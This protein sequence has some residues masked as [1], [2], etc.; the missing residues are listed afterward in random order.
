MA[1]SPNEKK[2]IRFRCP[3][4]TRSLKVDASLAG[5]KVLCPVCY[6]ELIVPAQSQPD[7]RQAAPGMLYGVDSTPRDNRQLRE[8]FAYASVHCPVCYADVAV[9]KSQI[10]TTIECPDCGTKLPVTQQAFD[11]GKARQ[12]QLRRHQSPIDPHRGESASR[13]GDIYGV[14]SGETPSGDNRRGGEDLIPVYCTLC[15]TLMYARPNQIGAELTCPDCETKVV[16]KPPAKLPPDTKFPRS[17]GGEV[18]GLSANPQGYSLPPKGETAPPSDLVPVRCPLCETLLYAKKSQIGKKMRCP[19]C[20]TDI[21]ICDLTVDQKLAAQRIEPT[22]TGGYNLGPAPAGLHENLGPPGSV[23]PPI[24]HAPASS[25]PNPSYVPR[26]SAHP[27]SAKRKEDADFRRWAHEQSTE[28]PAEKKKKRK[29]AKKQGTEEYNGW[30]PKLDDRGNVILTFPPPP[31]WPMAPSLFAPL[32]DKE[33]WF[34]WFGPIFLVIASWLLLQNLRSTIG[35]HGLGAI[36]PVLFIPCLLE[37][38]GFFAALIFSLRGA[39]INMISVFNAL[40]NGQK[41]VREW[42]NREL[43]DGFIVLLRLMVVELFVV[44]PTALCARFGIP[45]VILGAIAYASQILFFPVA[46]L[47]TL[48]SEHFAVPFNA[49]V[50]GALLRRFGSW[51]AFCL[52]SVLITAPFFLFFFWAVN[53]PFATW[54]ITALLPFPIPIYTVLLGRFGWVVCACIRAEE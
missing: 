14:R 40:A 16:V 42:E 31:R 53:K 18:Y 45:P 28:K 4:C 49:A 6:R 27:Q 22:M 19:D 46:F 5:Q 17:T 24:P 54:A 29:T 11:E 52:W 12:E 15:G 1:D 25:N 35:I 10:N 20:G 7:R 47:S 37:I 39:A 41:R 23:P 38:L 9:T 3:Q 51:L 32:F 36:P 43:I 33:F 2:T 26:Y 50:V 34:H 30:I 44:F 8:R 48:D 21:P 13:G